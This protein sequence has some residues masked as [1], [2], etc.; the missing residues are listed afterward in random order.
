MSNMQYSDIDFINGIKNKDEQI[1][2][3]FYQKYFRMVRHYILTNNGDEGQ[4]KDIYHDTL[5]TIIHIIQKPDFVLTSSLS[6]LIFAVSKR[7]WLKHLEKNKK[8]SSYSDLYHPTFQ[9]SRDNDIDEYIESYQEQEKNIQKMHMA[10]QALGDTCYQ[11]L[12]EFYYNRLSMEEIAQ[13][14]GY[15]NADVAK[16][17]KYKCLQRLKRQFFDMS[18]KQT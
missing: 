2:H 15:H 7:L 18:I 1:L 12:K 10:L 16:N 17:Q 9:V 6:T 14:L 13:K 5:I 4:A 8:F 3:A 11:L